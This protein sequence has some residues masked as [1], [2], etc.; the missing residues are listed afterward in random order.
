MGQEATGLS[1][2]AVSISNLKD[3]AEMTY[4]SP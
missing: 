3:R 2:G 4:Y 1:E